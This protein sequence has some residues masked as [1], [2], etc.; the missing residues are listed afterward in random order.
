MAHE[1]NTVRN[2]FGDWQKTEGDFS[3]SE[4]WE[5]PNKDGAV[6]QSLLGEVRD[7]VYN[8]IANRESLL[9]IGGYN[10]STDCVL[11]SSRRHY[12]PCGGRPWN[13]SL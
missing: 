4:R 9:L 10:C 3:L 8:P 13:S 7:M 5:Y 1:M 6:L 11:T 2:C 12:F